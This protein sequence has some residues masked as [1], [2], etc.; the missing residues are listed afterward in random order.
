MF[1]S[2]FLLFAV[3]LAVAVPSAQAAEL[4][5]NVNGGAAAAGN[6]Q[7]FSD[8]SD[9]N[10]RWARHFVFWDDFDQKEGFGAYEAMVAEEDRRGVKTLITVMSAKG[11]APSDHQAFAD[12]MAVTARTLGGAEAFEVWNEADEGLFWSGGPN[13]PAYVDVLKRSYSAIKSV[14][15]DALVVFS[16]TVGNNFGFLQA[17][18]DAGAKGSFDVMSV[19]TDTACLDRPPSYYYREPDG[20]IGRFAFLGYREVY[21][22]MQANGDGDKPIWM[23]E[24]GWS[25]AQHTCEFGA[26]AGQKPAGVAEDV[27]AAWLLEA[28]NCMERDPYVQVAMW[29]NNRDLSDDGKMANMYGLRRFDSSARPA[30]DAFRTW[31][32][33]GGRSQAPCGDFEGPA[34]QLIEPQPGFAL[35]PMSN[36]TIRA[37]SDAPDLD[38]LWF[39]VEGPGAEPLFAGGPITLQGEGPERAREWGGARDLLNGTHKLTVFA[40]DQLGNAGPPVTLSFTKGAVGSPGGGGGPAGTG[41]GGLVRFPKLRLRG[42]GRTR[43][44]TGQ[45]LPGIT[46]GAVRVEWFFKRGRRWK[47]QH[48]RA[49]LAKKPFRVRQ[50]LRFAGQWRVR[51]LYLGRGSVPRTA[52]CWFVF[53]TNRRS[54][55]LQCPR[56][57]V[58]PTR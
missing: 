45:A 54:S 36:L 37:R 27:Q 52:S 8:L 38:R 16:P 9:L 5:V 10:A 4:G 7:N 40:T 26:S 24:F 51:A 12:F 30:F 46:A 53:K 48:S 42:R 47:R 41:A 28:M 20:R 50:R 13:P 29:F 34:V 57:A 14:R 43:T 6:Q 22:V 56:G 33:G 49:V 3:L 44:F 39:G 32:S 31:G 35:G 17:A 18:Y 25:A 11:E 15:P 19:H 58:R 21:K 1:R 2:A 23:T 55:K